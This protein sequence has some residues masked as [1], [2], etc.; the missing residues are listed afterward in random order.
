MILIK[1]IHA[2]NFYTNEDVYRLFNV[3]NNL[4]FVEKEYGDEIENFNLILPNLNPVFSKLL[5]ESIEI[6]EDNSGVFRLRL[7]YY[8]TFQL[9][10]NLR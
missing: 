3:I 9:I 4:Q 5:S 8:I 10:Q 2:D 7:I 6:D 1:L